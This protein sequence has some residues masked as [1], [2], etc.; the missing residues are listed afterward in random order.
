MPEFNSQTL[1]ELTQGLVQLPSE[2][3]REKEVADLLLK[4]M[5]SLGYEKV[6]VDENGSVVGII[7]GARSGPTLLFDGHIDT[8]GVAPGIPWQHGPFSGEIVEGKLYGRGTTD[9][10]G[11][12]AAMIV[13]GAAVDHRR[14]AGRV[15]VS[16]SVMEEVLEGVA[17]KTVM[18]QE[19][20][21]YVVICEPSDLVLI[22]GGRGRAEIHLEAIGRPAHSSSPQEG[23]NAILAMIPAIGGIAE[24]PLPTHEIVGQGIM[25]LT[26]IIS[27][28]YPGHS[29]TP[30]RCRV[31]YDRRL[32]P[33]E[34][35][36]S[37]LESLARL[38]T[39][40]GATL[41]VTI[42]KGEYRTYT[43]RSLVAEKWFPAWLFDRSHPF[44]RKAATGLESAGLP[45]TF[46]SYNFC[47]NGAY[48]AGQAG[49]PTIGFGPSPEILA[50]IVDEY[51]EVEKLVKT[52]R[53]YQGIIE[54]VLGS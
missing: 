51:V 11:A 43:G 3:G 32:M 54:A 15:V 29:V 49:V 33:G 50:H 48:S 14:L 5:P 12:V 23:L 36:R 31:T 10:K 2:A 52:A 45:V 39:I 37:V 1:I 6:T 13:A 35:K 38:T 19:R 17:L 26:D 25:T 53:G 20:P 44:V 47:T 18:D 9:M 34:T 46:G 21:D 8:V 16:A 22:H 24:V 27:E 42:A 7:N 4:R 30:S 28:P 41:N 40:E